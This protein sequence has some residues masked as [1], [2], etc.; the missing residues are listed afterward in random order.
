MRLLMISASVLALGVAACTGEPTTRT[1]VTATTEG[2]PTPGQLAGEPAMVRAPVGAS[3]DA[4]LINGEGASAG[5]ATFR[6]GPQGVVIRVEATGLTP[7]WHGIHLHSVGTCDGPTF[8]TASDHVHGGAGPLVHGLLNAE[9]T[10][11]GDLPNVYAD[12]GGRVNA[13]IF[14][15][16]VRLA[17]EGPGQPLL[18]T[19]GSALLIHASPDD[20]QSQPIGGS[21]DRVACGVIAAG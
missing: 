18:D 19:D 8:D 5:S 4:P 21:G 1:E 16:F 15:P 9:A 3:A 2:A 10:G 20:Y 6:Q 14:T 12:A 11:A 7:G 17:D 13:E